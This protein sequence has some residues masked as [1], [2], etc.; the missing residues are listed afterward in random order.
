MDCYLS[1]QHVLQLIVI[2][3]VTL[4]HVM[5]VMVDFHI[6]GSISVQIP[7]TIETIPQLG[8]QT[9]AYGAACYP[10]PYVHHCSNTPSPHDS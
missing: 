4:S 7:V 3:Y 10:L 6:T 5:D 9:C 1:L 2:L 8:E